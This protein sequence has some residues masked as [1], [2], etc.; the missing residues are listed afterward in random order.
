[1]KEGYTAQGK[2]WGWRVERLSA[3]PPLEVS[4]VGW[5][6]VDFTLL[7][8]FPVLTAP[9]PQPFSAPSPH[10]TCW[11][12]WTKAGTSSPPQEGGHRAAGESPEGSPG[13]G[14]GLLGSCCDAVETGPA[15][16]HL[17]EK[18]GP[19]AAS[20][21]PCP[22][23]R[24]QGDP[25]LLTSHSGQVPPEFTQHLTAPPL[26]GVFLEPLGKKSEPVLQKGTLSPEKQTCCCC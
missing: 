15:P 19:N 22:G 13:L 26:P 17:R 3:A 21:V 8:S 14:T 20:L 5:G 10:C 2:G 23:E 7:L 12:G 1:M 4:C 11:S 16:W 6:R 25:D 9:L 18:R 24:G